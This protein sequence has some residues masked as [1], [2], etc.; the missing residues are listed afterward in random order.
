VGPGPSVRPHVC[1]RHQYLPLSRDAHRLAIRIAM[2][3]RRIRERR[4]ACPGAGLLRGFG[5][6]A[7]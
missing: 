5:A 1:D 7:G 6:E 3:A 4:Q 2:E